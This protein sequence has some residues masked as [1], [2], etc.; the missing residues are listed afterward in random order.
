[1]RACILPGVL[2]YWLQWSVVVCEAPSLLLTHWAVLRGPIS[3]SPPLT[4]T[5]PSV[6]V[7]RALLSYL[8]G[9]TWLPLS[10]TIL[11]LKDYG[12]ATLSRFCLTRHILCSGVPLTF[13]L[14]IIKK[15]RLI[16]F[17]ASICN[18]QLFLFPCGLIWEE[19]EENK[20]ASG[21]PAV[22][23]EHIVQ[24]RKWLVF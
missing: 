18:M 23:Q 4:D 21:I 20:D 2:F 16:F 17:I 6:Q 13:K 9:C 15:K 11:Q 10:P 3:P 22:S 14:W 7:S 12:N 24:K 5:H 8:A 19:S 1:M